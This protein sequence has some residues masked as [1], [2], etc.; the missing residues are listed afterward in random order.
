MS[1]DIRE[2]K[3]MIE[4]FKAQREAKLRVQTAGDEDAGM[5]EE[6]E[7][8]R[9]RE[10]EDASLQFDF[11]EPETQE[12]KIATNRRVARLPEMTPERRS[13]AWGIAAF[14]AAVS[15]VTYLPWL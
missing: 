12:R 3:E 13:F 14:A 7:K 10:D 1:E 5:V 4:A 15:A 11:K 8:K 6:P 2:Q 9:E